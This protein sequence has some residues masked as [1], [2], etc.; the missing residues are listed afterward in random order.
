MV[1]RSLVIGLPGETFFFFRGFQLVRR[2]VSIAEE[3]KGQLSC[4]MPLPTCSQD[5]AWC[6][7]AICGLRVCWLSAAPASASQGKTGGLRV[8]VLQGPWLRLAEAVGQCSRYSLGEIWLD[9]P[10]LGPRR[11]ARHSI[12]QSSLHL[13]SLRSAPALNR[14]SH[15][16]P[17]QTRLNPANQGLRKDLMS[18]QNAGLSILIRQGLRY[19]AELPK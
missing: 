14:A 15:T 11:P 10:L 9:L 7:G 1:G 3:F 6:S 18:K 2:D 4:L 16:R 17:R 8:G 12:F 13:T 19:R 5:Q